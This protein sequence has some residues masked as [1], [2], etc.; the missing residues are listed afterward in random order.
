MPGKYRLPGTY[1]L[2]EW[3]YEWW[4]L[5]LGSL[6]F[7]NTVPQKFMLPPGILLMRLLIWN[8]LPKE[9]CK[10]TESLLC[11]FLIVSGMYNNSVVY[12]CILLSSPLV[13]FI[14]CLFVFVSSSLYKAPERII[15]EQP[16]LNLLMV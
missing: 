12:L 13:L 5:T 7:S 8:T 1:L 16:E 4:S 15:Y 14:F 11:I 9:S 6:F 3:T 10:T 2:S